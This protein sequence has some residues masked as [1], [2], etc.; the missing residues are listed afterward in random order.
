MQGGSLE[1]GEPFGG[2]ELVQFPRSGQNINMSLV[3][4]CVAYAD[5]SC[6]IVVQLLSFIQLFAAPWTAADAIQPSHLE[7]FYLFFRWSSLHIIVCLFILIE[8]NYHR[9]W[10]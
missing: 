4:G 9:P 7:M 3:Y 6:F 1:V 10:T 2:V 8:Q 5:R